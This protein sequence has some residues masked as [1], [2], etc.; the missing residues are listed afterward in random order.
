MREFGGVE[1]SQYLVPMALTIPALCVAVFSPFAGWLSD[2][3]GR[4][5]LLIVSLLV[6]AGIG[7]MPY[8]LSD[9][10]QIIATRIGLGLTEAVIMTL[11][12]ALIGDYF[13]GKE[14]ERWIGIQFA[15]VSLS[16]IVLIAVGGILGEVL[17]SRGPFLLYLLAIPVALLA[18]F[19]LFEPNNPEK[20]ASAA[21]EKLPL[22]RV[23]LSVADDHTICRHYVLHDHSK[24]RR[25][26]RSQ[27]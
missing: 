11:A 22:G 9:L 5:I 3:V 1:G 2:R 16:A 25:N 10:L 24:A 19:V 27:Y 4:K 21:N 18:A 14:R 15:T 23:L 20:R 8:F 7:V 13:I 6:Y 26:S 12:T 17:G